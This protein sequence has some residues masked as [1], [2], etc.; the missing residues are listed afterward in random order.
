MAAAEGEAQM[1][2]EL[3]LRFAKEMMGWDDA[4]L[5]GLYIYSEA[6]SEGIRYDELDAAM[7][8]AQ[9]WCDSRNG[10]RLFMERVGTQWHVIVNQ[11]IDDHEHR[12]LGSAISAHLLSALMQAC[13]D[14]NTKLKAIS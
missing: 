6:Q 1:T 5:T 2:E 11:M 10:I 8:A 4:E 9:V 13:L 7:E 14:A 12:S 3:A